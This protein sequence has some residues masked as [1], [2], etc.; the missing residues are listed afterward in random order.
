MLTG[1]HFYNHTLKKAVSVFGTVFNNIRVVKHGGVEE[2][3]PISYGPRDKFLARLTSESRQDAHIAIKLPRMSFAITDL[4]YDTTSSLNK[5][6]FVA[7]TLETGPDITNRNMTKQSVPYTLGIELNVISKTQDEALQI[8]E[9]ILPTFVPEYTV[10][11]KDMYATG[12]SSDVPIILNSVSIQQD[13]EGDFESKNVIMYT[14][15]FTMKINFSG[16]VELKPLIRSTVV[17]INDAVPP[18]ESNLVSTDENFGFVNEE[19]E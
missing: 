10:A 15:S 14:L 17:N 2:R 6:N 1:Q 18:E 5:M 12:V 11:I 16:N 19:G 9:Q 4:T 13:Y 7:T 3:V 8:V